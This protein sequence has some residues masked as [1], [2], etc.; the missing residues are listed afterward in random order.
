MT[1]DPADNTH[2]NV[3]KS[4]SP[5]YRSILVS[6]AGDVFLLRIEWLGSMNNAASVWEFCQQA[7]ARGA[8]RF[9]FDLA[10]C[11]GMDSTFMGTL[12]GLAGAVAEV[13]PPGWVCMVNAGDTHRR[14]LA[15]VGADRFLR[16]K[17]SIEMAT[18]QWQALPVEPGSP[19][20]RL[21]VIQQ[22]H[23]NLVTINQ[24]NQSRF[25]SLLRALS[26]ELEA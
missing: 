9:A 16:F 4:S 3:P 20:R 8:R 25:S 23:A 11:K 18:I 5:V 10:S 7:L 17:Q 2:A 12:V 26:D 15:S 22:A 19:Q 6:R 21:A 13:D 14:S 1:A 24:R